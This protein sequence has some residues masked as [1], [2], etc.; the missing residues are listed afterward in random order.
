MLVHLNCN[1]NSIIEIYK[2]EHNLLEQPMEINVS[3][4]A[5]QPS[6][7]SNNNKEKVE[8][9]TTLDPNAIWKQELTNKIK[10]LVV[11]LFNQPIFNY[12]TSLKDQSK[13]YKILCL[14]KEIKEKAQAEEVQQESDKEKSIDKEILMKLIWKATDKKTSAL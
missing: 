5:S 6:K 2:K 10:K 8:E 1:Y 12:K 7:D 14:N 3:T 13:K 4:Q 11:I 9:E